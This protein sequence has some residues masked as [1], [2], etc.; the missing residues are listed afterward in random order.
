MLC[1][2]QFLSDGAALVQTD[3]CREGGHFVQG[4][5]GLFK[6]HLGHSTAVPEA[7][8]FSR[9]ISWGFYMV[10]RGRLLAA[11]FSLSSMVN[12]VLTQW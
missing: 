3:V 11:S 12:S 5:C 1:H 8:S 7:F 4:G 10:L 6:T 2:V 9:C